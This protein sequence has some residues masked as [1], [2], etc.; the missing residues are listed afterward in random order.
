[1]NQTFPEVMQSVPPISGM[2]GRGL[3][4]L[5]EECG[6]LTQI[7][8][9]KLARMDTDVHWDGQGSLKARMEEEIAD[10]RAAS[11]YVIKEFTLSERNIQARTAKKLA[12]Y[13]SWSKGLG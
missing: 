7:C 3:A 12:A 9:K 13:E 4:K 8:A 6:E 11:I 2:A 10:V 5:L 1:M